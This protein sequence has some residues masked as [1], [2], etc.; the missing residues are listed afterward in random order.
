ML[1]L[2]KER[3]LEYYK[4][5]GLTERQIK[6]RMKKEELKEEEEKNQRKVKEMTINI[7]WKK[8]PTWGFCPKAYAKIEYEDGYGE[9]ETHRASGCGYDKESTVIA[10][11]FN[12]TLK[13]KL[14][15][16]AENKDIDRKKVPYGIRLDDE[17]YHYFEGGVGT[18]CYY[19]IVEFLGGEMIHVADGKTFDV[20][21]VR[22]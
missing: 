7:E 3:L 14:W 6:N 18:S 9:S 17:Y 20:Y 1:E 8:S 22:F 11:V 13:Y 4:N 19:R 15:D 12:E 5:Q 10:D 2:K 21:S 16:L